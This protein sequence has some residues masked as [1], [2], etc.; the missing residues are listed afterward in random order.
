M[1]STLTHAPLVSAKSFNIPATTISSLDIL[2]KEFS[3]LKIADQIELVNLVHWIASGDV[4]SVELELTMPKNQKPLR[5]RG[6]GASGEIDEQGNHE[7]DDFSFPAMIKNENRS[8]CIPPHLTTQSRS[9]NR[10]FAAN[11]EAQGGV[12]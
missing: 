3:D 6:A 1:L 5:E 7:I 12:A 10:G 4:S 8:H 9:E 2:G 11:L